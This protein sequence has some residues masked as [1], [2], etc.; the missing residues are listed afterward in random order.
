VDNEYGQA[1]STIWDMDADTA[2]IIEAEAQIVASQWML[3]RSGV[4]TDKNPLEAKAHS[5]SDGAVVRLSSTQ[6]TTKEAAA[7][8]ARFIESALP[9]RPDSQYK[10]AMRNL[11]M[12]LEDGKRSFNPHCEM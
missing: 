9:D 2:T 11:R 8:I 7:A 1:N 6:V 10:A 3:F 5:L 12:Y 4:D